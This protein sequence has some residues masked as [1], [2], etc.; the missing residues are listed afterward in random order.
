MAIQLTQNFKGVDYDYHKIDGNFVIINGK[1][2]RYTVL[3]FKDKAYRDTL[4]TNEELNLGAIRKTELAVKASDLPD[5]TGDINLFAVCYADLKRSTIP[6]V[7]HET[8][9]DKKGDPV[10]ITPE[11]KGGFLEGGTDV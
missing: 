2:L 1:F 5:F 3:S 6:A 9:V 8:E 11:A 7:L 4:K 10:V